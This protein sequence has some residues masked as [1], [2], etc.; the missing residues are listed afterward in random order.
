MGNWGAPGGQDRGA[1]RASGAFSPK[2]AGRLVALG[3]AFSHTAS[4]LRNFMSRFGPAIK[5]ALA[6]AIIVCIGYFFWRTFRRNWA[7]I[8]AL[9][10]HP[11][12]LFVALS[13]MIMV[14]AALCS[15]LAWHLSVNSLAEGKG[16]VTFSQSIATVNTSSLT[17]YVPGKIWAY[18]FQ[19]YWLTSLGFSKSLVLYVNLVNLAI[20]LVSN[21]ILGL[22]CWLIASNRFVWLASLALGCLLVVD[23]A[24][25][26]FSGPMLNAG[27]KLLNRIFK[28]NVSYFR[29]S[30]KL[31][32]ELH[33][34]HLAAAVTSGFSVFL[35]CFGVG[36]QV[37]VHLG[38]L[39]T[40]ASLIA[41][42]AGYLAFMVPGGLG[43]REGLMYAM[44][45]GV[46]SGSIGLVLPLAARVASM[47]ADISVGA[48]A[49]KF[50]QGW[51][52]PRPE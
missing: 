39:I 11:N 17:K 37:D 19:M 7:S 49:L 27:V 36:Y 47:L 28:R 8:S 26:K 45:G 29:I 52:R 6:V 23:I 24:C 1:E 21:V 20:S 51:A 35:L 4:R 33:G 3:S 48:V 5:R 30:P 2:S 32:L 9:E 43:V 40:A 15:T 14:V 44:L 42:V 50:L 46:K 41:D 18:A 10:L 38:F 34:A 31:M 13:L 12:Y 22:V 16:H 25:I